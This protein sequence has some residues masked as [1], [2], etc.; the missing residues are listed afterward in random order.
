M[1]NVNKKEFSLQQYG[2]DTSEVCSLSD[3]FNE[4]YFTCCCGYNGTTWWHTI[5]GLTKESQYHVYNIVGC[6]HCEQLKF[7]LVN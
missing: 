2:F 7:L 5:A 1:T 6:P 4:G 3:S